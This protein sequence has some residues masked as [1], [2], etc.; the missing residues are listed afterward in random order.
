MVLAALLTHLDCFVEI[1]FLELILK[2]CEGRFGGV[3]GKVE[4]K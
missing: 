1:D 4:V 2:W 3:L